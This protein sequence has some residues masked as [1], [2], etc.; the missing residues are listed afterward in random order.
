MQSLKTVF[1]NVGFVYLSAVV[2]VFFSEK[3]YWYPSG[4][5]MFELA[6]FYAI[7]TFFL[8]WALSRFRVQRAA[9]LFLAAALF[10][11]VTEGVLTTIIYEGGLLDPSTFAYAALGWHG[12]IS[13]MFGWYFLRKLLLRGKLFPVIVWS[14]VAGI[15]WGVWSPVYWLPENLNNPDLLKPGVW[16]VSEFA[17]F[18]LTITLVLAAAQ[19]LLG[20]WFWQ[21]SFNPG[22]KTVAIMTLVALGYFGLTVMPVMPIIGTIKFAVL[23]ALILW[24]LS[25]FRQKEVSGETI[26]SQ[27]HGEIHW[28]PLLGLFAMPL[29]AITVYALALAIQPDETVIR[30]LSWNGIVT[31]QTLLGGGAFLAALIT[32]ALPHRKNPL[33]LAPSNGIR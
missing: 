24:G 20:K 22:K 11:L 25:R 27:L 21:P 31:L 18:A 28:L 32:A 3:M 15:F 23:A 6:I 2:L 9:A 8:L 12:L 26:F 7:P 33:P 19:W 4:G 16:T 10:G 1:F 13:V 30:A 14:T 5:E 17:V 29:A